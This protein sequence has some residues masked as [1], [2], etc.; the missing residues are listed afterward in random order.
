[1]S[2]DRTKKP[3]LWLSFI[4]VLTLILLLVLN[5][6]I[7]K[8]S[9][10]LGANQIALFVAAMVGAFLGIFVL[11]VPYEEIEK[12]VVHS[13]SLSMQA[14]LILLVVGML[15]GLWIF[16]GVVPA[17]IYYGIKLFHPA[18][19][20]PLTAI[21]CCIVSLAT[22][23][24][25]STGGTVGIA[26]IGVGQTLGIPVPMVAGA[27]IS[28]SYFG[29]KLSPLS[30]T[31]NL[32]PAMAGTNLFT[33]VRYMLVTTIPS[34]V[35]AIIG[36]SI[37]GYFYQG[38]ESD[39]G[40]VTMVLETLDATFN[41]TPFLFLLPLLVFTLVAK[42]VPALPALILGCVGGVVM[43]LVFQQELLGKM[44]AGGSIKEIFGKI[45][46]VA[47]VGFKIQTDKEMINSLLTRGGM[48]NMLN[49]VWLIMMSM[50]FGGVM[51]VT[52]MLERIGAAIMTMVRGTASLI[53]ATIASGFTI[54]L[55]AGDQYLSIVLPGRMFRPT[56]ERMGLAPQNL[57]R[58]LEDA[59]TITSVLIPWN[60]CGA[61]FAT[62]LGVPT[63]A[64]LP[65]CFFNL[66]N[67]FVAIAV[68]ATGYRIERIGKVNTAKEVPLSASTEIG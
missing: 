46:E 17:M 38:S 44:V 41:I 5:I 51:E 3:A 48:A 30:D 36:F 27:V 21:V 57:S 14:N 60:T 54:N 53:A 31:T 23:S 25:W 18:F 7:F 8:D 28:G 19:F 15:I 64:Y 29:D 67:P 65:F 49:T 6:D 13:I 63:A 39:L 68:A 43:I 26:L 40:Q 42:K 2:A 4:P 61:Y 58:S 1:M 20:L 59:G 22:G 50:V 35:I 45:V 47:F 34:I 56:Y 24:S 55:T 10:V 11:K 66:I 9:A 52:G 33:H 16:S 62:I 32:A 37:L 12:Q